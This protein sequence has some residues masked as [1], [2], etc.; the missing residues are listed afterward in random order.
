M[1]PS[2]YVRSSDLAGTRCSRSKAAR[3]PTHFWPH[4]KSKHCLGTIEQLCNQTKWQ[5]WQ[6]TLK[7]T[8]PSSSCL[9]SSGRRLWSSC[10]LIFSTRRKMSLQLSVLSR[11]FSHCLRPGDQRMS[12]ILCTLHVLI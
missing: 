6:I 8:F 11:S 9:S 3:R 4:L 12:C 10:Y 7:P 2:L 5:I 1:L